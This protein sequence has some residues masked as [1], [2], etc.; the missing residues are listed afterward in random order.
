MSLAIAALLTFLERKRMSV[1]S[2]YVAEKI[3]NLVTFFIFKK[4][5]LLSLFIMDMQEITGMGNTILV[6]HCET[7][8]LE[9]Q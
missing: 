8:F 5:L 1:M 9:R 3:E 4:P 6:N 2:E 7:S